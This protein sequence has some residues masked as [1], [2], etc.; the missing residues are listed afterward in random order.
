MGPILR[1]VNIDT[2]PMTVG[3]Y[4]SIRIISMKKLIAWEKTCFMLKE[5][6]RIQD[7]IKILENER[8]EKF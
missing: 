4:L 5:R 2:W 8:E 3:Y 6:C 1:Y 7:V